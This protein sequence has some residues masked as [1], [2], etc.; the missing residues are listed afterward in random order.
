MSEKHLLAPHGVTFGFSL[1]GQDG[2][3]VA[4]Q[5]ACL[6][7][8]F[9]RQRHLHVLRRGQKPAQLGGSQHLDS[10]E[11]KPL[12]Q[13]SSNQHKCGITSDLNRKM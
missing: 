12:T 5:K 11:S 1:Q 7:G 2:F 8:Y 9:D 3:A 13:A 6:G 10:V 4:L